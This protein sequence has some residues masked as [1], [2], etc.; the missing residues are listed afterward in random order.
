ME[1]PI[2][3]L[4]HYSP[5]VKN[6]LYVTRANVMRATDM[7]LRIKKAMEDLIK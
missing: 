5:V 1:V 6:Q 4:S 3:T 2:G 7:P